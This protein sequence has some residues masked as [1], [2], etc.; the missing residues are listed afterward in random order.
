MLHDI[1]PENPGI[2]IQYRFDADIFNTGDSPFPS[3][4][5]S[6]KRNEGANPKRNV[7]P[8]NAALQPLI[9]GPSLHFVTALVN[10][11]PGLRSVYY[12]H[13]N[14]YYKLPISSH[15]LSFLILLENSKGNLT[16]DNQK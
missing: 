6:L 2:N 16:E 13:P 15:A 9:P 1:P 3:E 14:S 8:E 4:L 11:M 12:T 7:T 10:S 5:P